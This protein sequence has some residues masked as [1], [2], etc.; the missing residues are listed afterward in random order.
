M[1][2]LIITDNSYILNEIIQINQYLGIEFSFD[3]SCSINNANCLD[4]VN[5]LNIIEPLDL[6]CANTI[7]KI[8]DNYSRV[9]SI[10]CKQLFPPKL[11]NKVQCINLHPGYNPVNRGWYPQ[12]FAIIHDFQIGATLHLI[13]NELDN[14][15][16]IDRKLVQKHSWDTSE[17]LYSRIVVAEIELWKKNILNILHDKSEVT[18]PEN[19]GNL[20][21]KRDFNEL[22]K[23]NLNEP[24][25]MG[26]AINQ[27][28]ALTFG[29]YKNAFFIDEKGNKVYVRIQL[30]KDMNAI[31]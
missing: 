3:L 6:K 7:N 2:N 12:V 4:N 18:K 25:T 16:I 19:K 8:I 24:I 1:K 21:L 27:L 14:G 15:L 30:E 31:K 5:S 13:D 20:F 10:H 17:S 29:E 26:D 28:R 23:L 9:F 22:C 11:V